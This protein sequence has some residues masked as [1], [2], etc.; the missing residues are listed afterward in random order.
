MG[1]FE[2]FAQV[3]VDDLDHRLG[4]DD[5]AQIDHFRA[6]D[7]ALVV[8]RHG[9]HHRVIGF[10]AEE[11]RRHHAREQ[12]LLAH[13]LR[14]AQR[15]GQVD[16]HRAAAGAG[17]DGSIDQEFGPALEVQRHGGGGGAA[18]H[19]GHQVDLVPHAA[20]VAHK[21]HL[22]ERVERAGGGLI[23]HQAR[24][25]RLVVQLH[26]LRVGSLLQRA[27][28]HDGQVHRRIG[29]AEPGLWKVID[30]ELKAL[31]QQR[32]A[33]ALLREHQPPAAHPVDEMPVGDDEGVAAACLNM[34]D[35]ER[36][37]RAL[38]AVV[39]HGI[40]PHRIEQQFLGGGVD[41]HG[42]FSQTEAAVSG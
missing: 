31:A 35:H 14:R 1:L 26:A 5:Q 19:D 37:A 4:L 27:H 41:I 42:L 13:A 3:R 40:D 16:E 34:A 7:H 15:V 33:V 38:T 25:D 2:P 17:I 32:L 18:P 24:V 30:V 36:G 39:Q 6:H 10:F 29:M 28:G 12:E 22:F 11:H 8:G 23:G 21:Q 9:C 20:G